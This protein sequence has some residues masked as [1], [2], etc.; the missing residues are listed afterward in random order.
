MVKIPST[1]KLFGYNPLS[2]IEVE[3]TGLLSATLLPV[4]SKTCSSAKLTQSPCESESSKTE[5]DEVSRKQK[6]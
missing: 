1:K 3:R 4:A 6:G 5:T 2:R